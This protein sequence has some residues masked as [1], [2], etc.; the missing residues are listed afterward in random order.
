MRRKPV[1]KTPTL[2]SND[3]SFDDVLVIMGF[4]TTGPPF[5]NMDNL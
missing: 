5:T 1:L 3:V 2:K 4:Q